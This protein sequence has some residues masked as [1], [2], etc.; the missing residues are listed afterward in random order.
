MSLDPDVPRILQ[1]KPDG[2]KSNSL[3]FSWNPPASGSYDGF[4]VT[5]L[6][7]SNVTMV[8]KNNAQEYEATFSTLLSGAQFTI[9]VVT[10]VGDQQS[11]PLTKLFYTS[12]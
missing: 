11:E 3:S 8:A 6:G 9:V 2:R 10:F 1:L 7:L 4:L 12:K 5:L